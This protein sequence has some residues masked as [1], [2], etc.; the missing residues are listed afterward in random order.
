MPQTS[1]IRPAA[2]VLL[3]RDTPG[4]LQVYLLHRSGRSAFLP[5]FH[6]FPGGAAEAAD[7]QVPVASPADASYL[8]AAAARE[9]FEETAVLVVDGPL[10]PACELEDARRRLLAGESV[11]GALLKRHD[12]RVDGAR[13][14]PAGIRVT[15][16]YSPLR[17]RARFFLAQVR[18]G[19]DPQPAPGEFAGGE[20]WSV[21]A[22]LRGWAAG[23]V[24]LVPPTLDALLRLDRYDLP[25]ALRSLESSPEGDGLEGPAFP[26]APGLF[27]VPQLTR[28]LPPASHTLC[29]LVGG[30]RMLVVDPG[31]PDPAELGLVFDAL[32]ALRAEG[33]TP[34]EIV[35]THHHPDHVGGASALSESLGI[36]IAAHPETADRLPFP[37]DRT[38]E[39]GEEWDLGPDPF[40]HRW[41]LRAVHTP[42]H[43]PGHLCLWDEARRFVIAGDMV[44]GVGTIVIDPPEGDLAQYLQSLQRLRALEP[45]LVLAAHGA[46]LGP[47]SDVFGRYLEH[48]LWREE[49][50]LA[51]LPGTEA[52]LLPRVYE[53][54]SPTL[55]PLAARSLLAHLLKLEAQGRAERQGEGWG[56]A[57]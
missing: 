13:L 4:G 40:G 25:E 38:I 47:G 22:A 3:A 32:Q 9:L 31:S 1:P 30:R 51:A 55:Y 53:D 5:G 46:P 16:P 34:T 56:P 7:N 52:D 15:P 20:W 21:A 2:G 39:D 19:E 50:V 24:L 35:L 41:G 44:A 48:R 57:P 54:V 29:V 37:V 23:N 36:P 10:P 8:V 33:R 6:C 17:F 45:R 12:L 27:Y 18:E 26:L 28:T 42:G 14:R 49:R 11:F 43:A